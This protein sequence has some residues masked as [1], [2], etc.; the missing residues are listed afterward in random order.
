MS[1][2]ATAIPNPTDPNNPIYYVNLSQTIKLTNKNYS[3]WSV[4]V[5]SFLEG[6]DL[7][8]YID[9]SHPRP[10][11]TTP[12]GTP[13]PAHA[14]WVRQDKLLFSALIG[15]VDPNI[16]SHISPS[17]TSAEAWKHLSDTF[18]NSSQAHIHQIKTKLKSIKKSQ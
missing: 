16:A 13:N 1:S 18:A 17:Q 8:R 9:G 5:R 15:T 3:T 2:H 12:A 4:Q 7:Y 10:P 6:F 14:T 11:K